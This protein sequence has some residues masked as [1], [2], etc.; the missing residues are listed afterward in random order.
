MKVFKKV[1]VLAMIF[2]LAIGLAACGSSKSNNN[3]SSKGKSTTGKSSKSGGGSGVLTIWTTLTG[4]DGDLVQKD[5]DNYN[6]TN[7]NYK[8]KLVRMKPDALKTKL[9]AVTRSGKGVPALTLI[10]SED[11]GPYQ[12]E[13]LL[14]P[15]DKY[16]KGTGLK[17]DNYVKA[18][19]NVA[20][21]KGKHYGIPGA[22]G[23]WVMYY[24][25][26]LVDKYAPGAAK[27]GVITYKE[28]EKAGAAA[29]KDGVY[30]MGFDWPMQVYSATYLQMG[31][32]YMKNGK[33]NVV[34]S[35]SIAT[36]NEFKKLR[37]QGY[38]DKKGDDGVKLF[39]NQKIIF[40]P[41]GTWMLS[42]MQKI[43]NFKWKET[44]TPQWNASNVINTSGAGQFVMFRSKNRSDAQVKGAVKFLDWLRTNETNWVKSGANSAS[45]AMLDKYKDMPQSFLLSPKGRKAVKIVTAPDASYVYSAI[46]QSAWDMINGKVGIKKKL[47]TIQ[48]SVE[49]KMQQ[50]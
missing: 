27:D 44:Y 49:Q 38:M 35:K 16:I 36:M 9:A 47:T 20:Q 5:F 32:K 48:K 13:G 12:S 50:K 6:A 30:A 4:P 7:P 37:D 40:L 3:A 21:I 8:V 23:S 45:L 1:W 31:G 18:A 24:N 39:N 10:A 29:K 26:N 34:N 22:M 11:V 19:W 14:V 43:K 46:D 42:T 2:V 41:E 17:A 25:K 28:I 33:P 15:Y